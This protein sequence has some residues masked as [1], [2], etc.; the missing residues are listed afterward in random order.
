MTK[1]IYISPR[2]V[3]ECRFCGNDGSDIMTC[4]NCDRQPK[5]LRDVLEDF[6]AIKE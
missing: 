6:G 1:R 2:N 3:E 4:K 5:T